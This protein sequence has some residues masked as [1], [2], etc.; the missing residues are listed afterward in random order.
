MDNLAV[1]TATFGTDSLVATGTEYYPATSQAQV[2]NNT[3]VNYYA[4]ILVAP[5]LEEAGVTNGTESRD[6]KAWMTA[7]TYTVYGAIATYFESTA[8]TGSASL[9][10]T[11]IVTGSQTGAH[12]E[13]DSATVIVT[14]SGWITG[15]YYVDTNGDRFGTVHAG[16][17]YARKTS[18]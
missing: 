10:G 17:L 15:N 4:P 9:D 11:L 16:A 14:T 12:W 6:V 5:Q 8:V 13:E 7:G 2:V 3:G 18:G 1:T